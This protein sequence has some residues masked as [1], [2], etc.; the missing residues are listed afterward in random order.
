M[1]DYVTVE[2]FHNGLSEKER[3]QL[4]TDNA[5]VEQDDDVV[6]WALDSAQSLIDTFISPQVAVPMGSPT[7]FIKQMNVMLAKY[8]LFLRRGHVSETLNEEFERIASTDSRKPG[9]LFMMMNGDMPVTGVG[10]GDGVRTGS[11]DRAYDDAMLGVQ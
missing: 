9:F 8:Y 1:P 3:T 2:E 7:P 10:Q 5:E 11:K 4:S 6:T